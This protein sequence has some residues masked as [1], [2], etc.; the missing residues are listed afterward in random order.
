MAEFY[1]IVQ[2]Q[3]AASAMTG[4]GARLFGGRWNPP[5]V[6]AVYLAD[7]RALAAL[8]IIVHAPREVM[9][10]PWR[11]FEVEVPDDAIEAVPHD[12]LPDDWQALPSS[13]GARLHGLRC[14]QGGTLGFK[15]PSAVI[16]EEF[17][18]LLNPL[19]PDFG[20]LGVSDPKVF[21]F[22]PRF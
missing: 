16:P 4:E 17:T 6:P 2:A 7:S 12:A 13:P 19:H 18:L 20:N 1:R 9:A 10:L 15:L 22:D 5:G 3:W 14:L 21:R 8:E 11:I